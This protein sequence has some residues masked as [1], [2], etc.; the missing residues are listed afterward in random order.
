MEAVREQD[1]IWEVRPRKGLPTTPVANQIEATY[2][3]PM[4]EGRWLF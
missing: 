3:R 1:S 4:G 2:M